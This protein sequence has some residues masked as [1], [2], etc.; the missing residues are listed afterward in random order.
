MIASG[1]DGGHHGWELWINTEAEIARGQRINLKMFA[2]VHADPRLL[3]V[4]IR[5]LLCAAQR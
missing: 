3:V 5:P 4:N 1:S 2:V